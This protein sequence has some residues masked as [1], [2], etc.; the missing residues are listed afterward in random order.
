MEHDRLFSFAQ[1]KNLSNNTLKEDDAAADWVFVTQRTHRLLAKVR[2]EIWVPDPSLPAFSPQHEEVQSAGILVIRYPMVIKG[3]KGRVKRLS[4]TLTGKVSE[5][6]F[7]IPLLPTNEQVKKN[8]WTLEKMTIW[9]D[10]PMAINMSSIIPHEFQSFLADVSR[11][12]RPLGLFRVLPNHYRKVLR[13]APRQ[14]QLGY[15][16]IVGFADAYPL[17]IINIASVHDVEKKRTAKGKKLSCQ[18]FRP[19]IIVEGPPAYAEDAWKRVRIGGFE[20]HVV[21]RTARCMLPN[22]DQVTGDRHPSEPDRTLR[23]FRCIDE[24]AGKNACLGMM[25]VPVTENGNVRIGDRVK[26]LETGDHLYIMQ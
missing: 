22:V 12:A 24:G 11:S 4:A 14:E 2:T 26:V 18:Q 15:Q 9:K 25:M 23:S 19:N 16:S 8:G 5:A 21:C 7:K 13:C 1:R 20:H 10:S 6:S 17:H 3:F